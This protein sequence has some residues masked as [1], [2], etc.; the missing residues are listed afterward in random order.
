M[1]LFKII[2]YRG[3]RNAIGLFLDIYIVK[4]LY[5]FFSLKNTI[6]IKSF[7]K[8][9]YIPNIEKPKTFNEKILYKK[10]NI[11]IEELS[12]YA[13]KYQVRKILEDKG[14]EKILNKLYHQVENISNFDFTALPNSFVMKANHGS[15]MI[16]I[17]KDKNYIG[18][19]EINILAE[20]WLKTKY[21]KSVGGTEFHYDSIKPRI[22]FEKLLEN[23]D[24]SPLLDYKFYCFNGKVEFIDIVDNS[25]GIPLM[26]VYDK[27]WQQLPFA[28]YNKFLKGNLQKPERLNEMIQIAENLSSEFDFVRIDLYLIDNEKIVFGEYTFFPGGGML[29]FRPKKYD[30]IFGCKL[31]L[32]INV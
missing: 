16:K 11:N 1:K 21:N 14:Y 8:I 10:L 20:K 25:N 5:R 13:D 2:K 32:Q 15:G 28:L 17:V 26:Y 22:L 9:G 6:R 7:L 4:Y 23:K 29:K 27:K 12:L 30:F 18:E 19:T 3:T 24:G 31:Q